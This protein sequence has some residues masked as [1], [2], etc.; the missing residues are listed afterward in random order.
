M[1]RNLTRLAVIVLCVVGCQSLFAWTVAMHQNLPEDSFLYMEFQGTNQ[2]RWASDYLKARAGGRYSG[3][4]VN[5][6][7]TPAEM[8]R[9]NN[10]QCGAIGIHRVGGDKIDFLQDNFI[11]HLFF[12]SWNAFGNNI[13]TYTHFVNLNKVDSSGDPLVTNNYNVVDGYSYNA[14]Y[15]FQEFG[16]IDSLIA[17][18]F[19]SSPFTINVPGCTDSSCAEWTWAATALHQ[20]PIVD[21]MQNGSTTPLGNPHGSKQIGTD[22]GT[23]YNCYSDTAVI[24]NCP[25]TGSQLAGTYQYPNTCPGCG[26]NVSNF[27]ESNQ[28]WSIWEPATNAA[29]FYYNEGWLEGL[30]SRNHSLQMGPIAGRYYNVSGDQI[31]YYTLTHHYMGDIT[32]ILHVWVTSGYGHTDYESYGDATYGA[33]AV[34]GSVA[35]NNVED[36]I[37]SQGYANARQNRYNLPVGNINKLIMEQAFYTYHIRLRAGY[38]IMST[39]NHSIWTNGITYAVQNSTAEMALVN[40]KAVMD[41]RKCRNSGSCDNR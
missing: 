29:T 33:R 10:V 40:E 32:Q 19:G 7:Y 21:Y 24:G 18:G 14:T 39:S 23:N 25:D 37:N 15:G 35:G 28:D 2:M 8:G 16:S 12:F 20:N 26:S 34:G 41:L 17:I 1:F 5:I 6:N 27:F 4:C 38:D 36:Y 11:D 13:T 9:G 3:T 22:D 31:L 30:A